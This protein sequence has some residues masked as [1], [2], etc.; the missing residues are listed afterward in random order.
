MTNLNQSDV[1]DERNQDDALDDLKIADLRRVAKILGIRAQRDWTTED[2][3]VAIKEKQD[4]SASPQLVYDGTLAPKPGFARVLVHRDMTPGHKNS[5]IHAAVNGWIFA[6]PR[7]IE[8]DVP[9]EIVE[10]LKNAR[11]F[12]TRAEV[13]ETGRNQSV[14]EDLVQSYP[15]Q[16]IA[17]S[18]GTA[19]NPHDNRAVTANQRQEFCDKFGRYPTQGELVKYL[20]Q[21]MVKS[22]A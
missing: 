16:V 21:K 22:L 3:V 13:D 10:V 15:F 2:F 4:Q 18:P 5:A 17:I 14:K 8:V 20:E 19:K 6:I 11:S 1:Q 7:G 12:V 9:K